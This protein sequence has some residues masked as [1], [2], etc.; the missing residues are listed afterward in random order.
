MGS[1]AYRRYSDAMPQGEKELIG[2]I[3]RRTFSAA[4][5]SRSVTTGIGDDAAVLRLPRGHDLLVTTDFSLENVHFRRDWHPPEVVGWRCLAR[6]LSDIAAMG[7]EPCAAFLSLAA[8]SDVPQRW[9]DQFLKGL[10]SLAKKFHVPLAGGDTAEAI[11]GIQADIVVT[12]TVP[13]GTAVLRSGAKAGDLIYVTGQLGGSAAD[14]S[15]LEQS[16]PV[17]SPRYFR[18]LPRLG[19]GQWLRQR[20]IP[21]AMIDISDG[22][23]TDLQHICEESGCRAEI[24]AKSIPREVSLDLALHGGDDYELLFTSQKRVP[25][26]VEGV[27]IARIGQITRGRG[28]WIIDVDGTKK[29]L[30][31]MGWEHFRN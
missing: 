21:S 26:K 6:G 19:V 2:R 13:R 3:R 10:L 24:D 5:R 11:L 31:P 27:R 12:G 20:R 1:D 16:L 4:K 15:R 25:A 29:K 17:D 14:L 30:E 28:M 23:S 9:I 22:L 8:A 7:G 18:P